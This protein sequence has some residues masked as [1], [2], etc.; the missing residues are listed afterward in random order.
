MLQIRDMVGSQS[1]VSRPHGRITE[2]GRKV[3]ES[4]RGDGAN[5]GIVVFQQ[6]LDYRD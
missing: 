2:I 5:V 1:G 4:D 6:A 3:A